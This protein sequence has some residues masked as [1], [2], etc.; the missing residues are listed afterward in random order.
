[1]SIFVTVQCIPSCVGSGICKSN[2]LCKRKYAYHYKCI[3]TCFNIVIFGYCTN[4]LIEYK[5]KY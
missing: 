1:M 4:V 3:M 2:C 5:C